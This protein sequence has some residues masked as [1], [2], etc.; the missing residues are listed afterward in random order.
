M[1]SRKHIV[2]L[3]IGLTSVALLGLIVL[4]AFLL[5]S[6]YVLKEQAFRANVRGA[7]ISAALRNQAG[8]TLTQVLR[9]ESGGE[10]PAERM[11]VTQSFSAI[12][13]SM[14]CRDSTSHRHIQLVRSHK[15]RDNTAIEYR[16]DSMP[17]VH[18]TVNGAEAGDT[19]R[20][21]VSIA[22]EADS[23]ARSA[24]PPD[25]ARAVFISTVMDNL[26][27]ND[28]RPLEQRIDGIR[29][30]SILRQS[31]Q[32]AGV[33]LDFTWGIVTTRGDGWRL[34]TVQMAHPPGSEDFLIRS[35]FQT[36]LSPLGS[37]ASLE[38]L[39]V[40]FPGRTI[41]VLSQIWPA[42][43]ASFLFIALL[44][45]LFVYTIRMVLRQQRLAAHMVDFVNTMT[46]E[47]KT[48]LSTVTLATEAI[49]RPD[50]VGRKAKVLQ[51]SRMIADEAARMKLQADRILQLAQLETGELELR[52]APINMHE[53]IRTTLAAFLVQVEARKGT[54]TPELFA[55]DDLVSGDSVHL[56][57]VLRSILDNANKY[58]SASPRIRLHTERQDS[59]FV[60][61]VSDSGIGM[62]PEH[63]ERVFEKFYR[64]PTG[65]L[66]D[67][68]GF[69]IGLSYVKRILE[70]HNG[71]VRLDS[72]IGA[73]TTVTLSIPLLRAP[74]PERQSSHS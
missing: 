44:T 59:M 37:R 74:V 16:A 40:E 64:V 62:A 4:Q 67:V 26:R 1:A 5:N 35:L 73:G 70:A 33:S 48:P 19:V 63:H 32:E 17:T 28:R 30:D 72:A 12:D 68:K 51:Y 7:L 71:T 34:D 8:E 58:S 11:I 13:D 24:S 21:V 50:V 38:L 61:R 55:D 9:V 43:A 14:V 60:V 65:N 15:G 41:Y 56:G 47:F 45:L 66:H 36:P 69:G 3:L 25:S 49:S 18:L 29:L 20:T 46:H 22:Q 57:N 6:A 2:P 52:C 39:V 53:L 54:L 27:T 31:M 42:L 10:Y 23:S